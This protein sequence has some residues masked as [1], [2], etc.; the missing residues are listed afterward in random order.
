MLFVTT[1]CIILTLLNY[2]AVITVI[3]INDMVL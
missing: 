1:F 2:Y 3:F